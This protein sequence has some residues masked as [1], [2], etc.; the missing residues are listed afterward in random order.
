MV[1]VL[2]RKRLRGSVSV[3]ITMRVRVRAMVEVTS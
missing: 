1:R 3:R 2:R